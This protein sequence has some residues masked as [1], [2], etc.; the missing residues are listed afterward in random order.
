MW[1]WSGSISGHVD[2]VLKMSTEREVAGGPR[3]R[4]QQQ[5]DA[6]KQMTKLAAV[7]KGE[8]QGG[9]KAFE[10]CVWSFTGGE[11]AGSARRGR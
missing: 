1:V 7:V 2:T 6:L 10:P 11:S 5:L 8:G 9:L 4:K 3:G